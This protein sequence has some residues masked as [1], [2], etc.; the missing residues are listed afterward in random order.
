MLLNILILSETLHIESE[1]SE[2]AFSTA[3]T[4]FK[5]ETHSNG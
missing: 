5:C 2:R 4:L 1:A 3:T